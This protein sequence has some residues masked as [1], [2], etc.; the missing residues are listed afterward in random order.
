MGKNWYRNSLI[1][2]IHINKES[3]SLGIRN[4]IFLF[5][6]TLEQVLRAVVNPCQ[7]QAHVWRISVPLLS[8]SVVEEEA[9]VTTLPTSSH[10]GW[11]H[12]T[13]MLS[14]PGKS[15]IRDCCIFRPDLRFHMRNQWHVYVTEQIKKSVRKFKQVNISSEYNLYNTKPS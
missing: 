4:L 9:P 6:S 5:F 8:L 14:S 2:R 10:S 1:S 13:L 15:W 3:S 11:Q 12:L 7:V